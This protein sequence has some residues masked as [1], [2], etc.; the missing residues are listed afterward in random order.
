MFSNYIDI[1]A[2]KIYTGHYHIACE[3]STTIDDLDAELYLNSMLLRYITSRVIIIYWQIQ[4]HNYPM[5]G[6]I[7]LRKIPY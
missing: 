6:I 3:S 2:I 7:R 5:M 1:S 4:Y